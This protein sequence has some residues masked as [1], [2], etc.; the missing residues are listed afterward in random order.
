MPWTVSTYLLVYLV[1]T[2]VSLGFMI[3]QKAR[4]PLLLFELASASFIIML[5]SAYFIE[6]LRN[7]LNPAACA[8]AL[9]LDIAINIKLS[10][11]PELL[12]PLP[13]ETEEYREA[14]TAIGLVFIAPAYIIAGTLC[15]TMIFTK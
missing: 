11:E 15:L 10:L 1:L 6:S 2:L 12:M 5:V 9:A 8:V 13:E 4:L 14:G 3:G 7:E